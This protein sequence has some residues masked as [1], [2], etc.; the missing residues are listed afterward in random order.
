MLGRLLA[1]LGR[2]PQHYT[3]AQLRAFVLV[4]SRDYSHSKAET[5]ITV[6]RMFV[7]FL[8]ATGQCADGLQYAIPRVAGW[9]QASLPRYLDPATVERIIAGGC[10]RRSSTRVVWSLCMRV[11]WRR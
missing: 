10:A 3:A 1:A 7:R 8:I 11:P 2:V 6:V 9:R 4:Q 5:V